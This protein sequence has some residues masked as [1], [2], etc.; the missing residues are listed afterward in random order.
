MSTD[1]AS[2]ALGTLKTNSKLNF[3]A[4]LLLM[5]LALVASI[6]AVAWVYNRADAMV[7]VLSGPHGTDMI[8]EKL[9]ALTAPVLLLAL[10]AGLAA[11]AIA[12]I[13]SRGLEESVRTLDSV[14]RLRREGEVAVS[15]RGL[16]VAFEEQVATIRKTHTL[17]L[18][19]GRTLF[20][21]TLGLFAASVVDMAWNGVSALSASLGAGSLVGAIFAVARRVP[22]SV[23]HDAANVVQL[24][25]IVTGAHRQISMLE[26]NAFAALNNPDV[27]GVPLMLA[28]Q[29]RIERVIATAI[30]QIEQF[31]DPRPASAKVLDFPKAA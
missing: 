3:V 29:D 17:L 25:L 31:A 28:A 1:V 13:H 20:I 15:A 4:R 10:F 8:G 22:Q 2:L 27:D 23:A 9:L 19:L 5:L 12:V 24:Q 11:V 18:W 6:L 7:K 26:A 30:A 21:V 14:N 16:M